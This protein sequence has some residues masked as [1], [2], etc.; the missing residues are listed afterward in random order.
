MTI[1][2]T[3]SIVGPSRGIP[4]LL[5]APTKSLVKLNERQP[6]VQLGLYQVEFR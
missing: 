4:L 5:P 1:V 2:V 3:S 6:L